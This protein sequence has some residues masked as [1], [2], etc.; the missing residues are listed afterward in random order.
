MVIV[1]TADD[2]FALPLAVTLYSA[3]A[4]LAGVKSVSLYIID[5]G[6]SEENKS[7]LIEVLS[8][9]HVDVYVSW[10]RPDLARLNGLR[11]SK[12]H[13]NAAYL[14]LLIPE[15]MPKEF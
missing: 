6:I 15:L 5:G 7:K 4:N 8:A 14:R 10:I 9:E 12:W 11:T 1:T 2:R 13:S 3:L